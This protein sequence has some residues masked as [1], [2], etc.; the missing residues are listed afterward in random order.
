LKSPV[1][2]VFLVI[3]TALAVVTLYVGMRWY[4]YVSK[5]ASPYEEV[6]IELNS[7]APGPL[8]RW[9]C[10]QLQARFSNATPPY[11]CATGNG[12]QWK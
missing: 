12:R 7:R 5:S 3:V 9:G 10:A 6:G 8:N 4:S 11:G 1:L 2:K